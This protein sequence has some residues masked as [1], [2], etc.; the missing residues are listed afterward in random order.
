MPLLCKKI[1]STPDRIAKFTF[2]GSTPDWIAN[3]RLSVDVVIPST[4]PL[5]S[6]S[7]RISGLDWSGDL[8]VPGVVVQADEGIYVPRGH[9]HRT[10][11][12]RGKRV[13]EGSDVF[14]QTRW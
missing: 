9:F 12:D 13:T 5:W 6:T 3:E 7:G 10:R 1:S 11:Q 2:C 14:A 4:A 8:K